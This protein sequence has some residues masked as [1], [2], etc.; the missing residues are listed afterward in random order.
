MVV[1]TVCTCPALQYESNLGD[2]Q[3]LYI[4]LILIFTFSVVSKSHD[5]HMTVVVLS[6][7]VFS[8]SGVHWSLPS[9]SE[10]ETPG[11]PGRC[12]CHAVSLCPDSPPP[13]R[14]AGSLVLPLAPTLVCLR[15]GVTVTVVTFCGS[16]GM[17]L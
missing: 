10:A 17:F 4:D 8:P 6:H 2:L 3:Y 13:G 7:D 15:G 16:P 12:P 14:P 1:P 9:A 11:D 5:C